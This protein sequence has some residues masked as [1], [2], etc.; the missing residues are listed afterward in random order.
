VAIQTDE[1]GK[2][3]TIS[4]ELL[5]N[6]MYELRKDR[7]IRM[8]IEDRKVEEYIMLNLEELPPEEE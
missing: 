7:K 6:I 5:A 1:N 8:T 3:L 4:L 2:E